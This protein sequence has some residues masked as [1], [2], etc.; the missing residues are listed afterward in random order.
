MA[1][2]AHPE[3]K[4]ACWRSTY[5]TE[6]WDQEMVPQ[7]WRDANIVTIYKN[8]GDK[9]I[10]GNSQGISLLAVA[11]KVL[12]KVM[13]HRLVNNITE[14]LLPESQC[15]FRK[16][17]STVDMIFTEQQ[18]QE[19]CREQH[20]DFFMA[21]VDLSKAFDTV[22]RELLR[23]ILLKFGCPDKFVNILCQFHDGMMA[24]VAIGGQES[25]PFG[26]SIGVRQGCV[27]LLHKELE[28]SSGVAVDFRLDGNL[29]NIGSKQPP[30]F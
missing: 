22:S 9:S 27:L 24:W 14:E 20:Q 16:N 11:G 25:V 10:C 23:G 12:A 29:F 3:R 7:Q 13:L 21:F 30:W 15:G 8:N 18:L 28:D 6:V 19:K 5:I 2:G 4:A 1:R 26:V 17:S